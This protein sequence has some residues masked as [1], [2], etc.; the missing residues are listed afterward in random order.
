MTRAWES[1]RKRN[2]ENDKREGK[3]VKAGEELRRQYQNKGD[4]PEDR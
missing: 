4:M 3:D 1:Q 2:N